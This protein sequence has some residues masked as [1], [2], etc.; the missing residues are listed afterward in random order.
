M[1]NGVELEFT[2]DVNRSAAECEG[3]V[4]VTHSLPA[5]ACSA[6]LGPLAGREAPARPPLLCGLSG[7]TSPGFAR[8]LP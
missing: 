7:K 5:E 2:T 6:L 1:P 3:A 4:P 8:A